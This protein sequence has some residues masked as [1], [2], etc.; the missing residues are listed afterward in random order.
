MLSFLCPGPGAGP[1]GCKCDG[2]TQLQSILMHITLIDI[3]LIN[4][5]I[6]RSPCASE[7]SFFQNDPRPV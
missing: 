1:G 7:V 5:N 2:I 4:K 3:E 6:K